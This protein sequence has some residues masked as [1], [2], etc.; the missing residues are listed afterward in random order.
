MSG[1]SW[2]E[3]YAGDEYVFGVEPNDFLREQAARIP[4]GRVLCLGEGEGRNAAYLAGL[5]HDV[6]AVDQSK[7]G[8]D[9]ARAL[10]ASRGLAA[11]LVTVVA[12]LDTWE[13]EP[14]AF[15]G[16]VSIFVHLPPPLRGKVHA[17]IRRA[18]APG[19]VLILQAYTPAQL[20]FKTGGPS[21]PAMLYT[22]GPTRADFAGFA[23]EVAEE[24]ER[25]VSEGRRHSGRAAVMQVVARA[26]GARVRAMREGEVAEV[27]AMMMALWSDFDGD[28]GGE[29]VL[30]WDRGDGGPLGGFVAYAVRAHGEGCDASGPVPWIEGWWVAPE[31]RRAGIGRALIAA[32]EAWARA[33]GFVELGSDVEVDNTG[34]L[35]AHA[36]LGFEPTER[37][38]YFHKHLR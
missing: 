36:A 33:A 38:Q 12:D 37:I 9:K 25:D 22:L 6:V 5:G 32:V 29:H 10:A 35:D 19:G 2:D 13:P 26:P 8:L 27:H 3:R 31:L 1:N 20:A 24:L 7:V 28:T 34:S 4:P 18:L 14:G 30:V 11:R 17:R 23:F 21:D 16:V 15:A